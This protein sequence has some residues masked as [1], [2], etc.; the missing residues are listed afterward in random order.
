[1]KFQVQHQWSFTG[2]R[3]AHWCTYP[4]GCFSTT[5]AQFS[6]RSLRQ[7][8]LAILCPVSYP[9]QDPCSVHNLGLRLVWRRSAI[10]HYGMSPHVQVPSLGSHHDW[11]LVNGWGI[12]QSTR[13]KNERTGPDE[14]LLHSFRVWG[15]EAALMLTR[16][17]GTGRG[18]GTTEQN[19]RDW[20]S[21]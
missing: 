14:G 6:P 19:V 21:P 12:H 8:K 13:I 9:N 15:E 20:G 4:R 1:M 3:H 7:N 11:I 17:S 5:T 10:G 16:T 18:L 2:T